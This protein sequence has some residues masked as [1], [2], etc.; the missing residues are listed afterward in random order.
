MN[1][2]V[3][4]DIVAGESPARRVY[5]D[6]HS[7][8]FMNLRQAN[9]GHVLVI[10]RK[11]IPTVFE[12]DAETAGYLFQTV[13]VV[14]RAVKRCFDPEGLTIWQSNGT[15]AAQEVFHV[16]IHLLP[17]MTDDGIIGFYP[18]G[19]PPIQPRIELDALAARIRD[20]L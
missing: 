19:I 20:V 1:R 3:F 9:P 10:P 2:C 14:A 6:E 7:L 16:H 17:R 4:C 15:T 11:H 5:E 13:A 8:A 12:L 18:N